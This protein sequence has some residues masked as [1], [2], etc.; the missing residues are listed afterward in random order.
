MYAQEHTARMTPSCQ[1]TSQGVSVKQ[2]EIS[3]NIVTFE[4]IQWLGNNSG[5]SSVEILAVFLWLHGSLNL[6]DKRLW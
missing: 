5:I 6:L 1:Q 3:H 4:W 2:Y